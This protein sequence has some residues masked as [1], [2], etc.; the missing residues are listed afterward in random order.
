MA[1]LDLNKRGNKQQQIDE[2]KIA[3]NEISE[4]TE[5]NVVLTVADVSGLEARLASIEGRLDALEA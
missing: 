1:K 2:I 3:L 4:S 5:E